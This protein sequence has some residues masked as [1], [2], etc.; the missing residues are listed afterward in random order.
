M[1]LETAIDQPLP[2]F[3]D[4]VQDSQRV[5]RH[6]LE[7]MAHPGKVVTLGQLQEA[8]APLNR[9][10]AAICMSL[11]DFET[12]L[13]TDTPIAACGKAITHLRF[14]CGCPVTA[15]PKEAPTAVVSDVAALKS[16][17]HF[18]VGT[19][20]R[21]DLSTTVIVQVDSF[22]MDAGVRLTGPGIQFENRLKVHGVATDFWRAVQANSQLFPRGVD[23]ILTS[24]DAVVCLPRTTK[25]EV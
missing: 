23:I 7:A 19:D 1:R 12:P 20:E 16:F 24:E 18:N 13:W 9:A 22:E 6:V 17:D 2:G 5:F 8:P 3:S 25:V 4:P 14:H 21:P 10:T 15:A 11:V